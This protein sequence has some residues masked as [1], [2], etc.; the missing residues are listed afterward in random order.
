MYGA[1]TNP[2]RK[3]NRGMKLFESEVKTFA[4][5]KKLVLFQP[6]KV[7][8]NAEFINAV[9]KINPDL[10][11]VVAYGKILPKEILDIPRLGCINLHA[12]LLPKYRGA[13][14]IQWAVLNGDNETRCY[15]DVYE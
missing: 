6:E 11:C 3:K 10:I 12:S 14:P 1:V 8:E 2:D 4:N 13:A 5:E 9:K 7:K 15:N